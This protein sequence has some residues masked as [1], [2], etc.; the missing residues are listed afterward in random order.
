MSSGT[1]RSA[2]EALK[3]T[4]RGLRGNLVAE[5]AAGG[6]QVSE[7]AYN[8]LKFHGSYEQYDRDTATA[9]KKQGL[10]KDYGFMVRLRAPGGRLTAAQYL[11]LDGLADSHGNGTMRA[12]T[13]QTLQF[14][15]VRKDNL[16]SLIAA[17]NAT[18]LTTR[19]TCGDVVRNVITSPAPVRDAV[20]ARLEADARL[21]STTL[22]PRS[23]AY[24][25]IFLDEAP[26][27]DSGQEEEPLLGPAY[28]PRKFKIGIAVPQDNT[29]DALSN[30]LAFI[31]VWEGETLR[32]YNVAVGGGLGMT[33]NRADTYPRLASVL[34]SVGPDALLAT[35]EAVIRV[36]RDNGNRADRKRARLKYVVDDKGID[37]VR[38]EVERELGAKLADPLPTPPFAM[39][40]LLGWHAQ[41]DGRWWL[42]V[43]VPSGRIADTAEVRLRTALRRIVETFAPDPI[44]TPQQDLLLSNIA[45]SD[46]AAITALLREHGVT[47]AEELTPFARWALACPALPTCGLALTEAERV[48]EPIVAGLEAVLHRLGLTQERISLRITGCPNGCAHSYGGDIGLVGRVP[49]SYAIFV[50]GD[51]A[52]TRLSFKLLERVP[53]A[54]IAAVLAPLLA[55]YAAERQGGEGFGDYCARRGADALLGLVEN[56]RASAA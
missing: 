10:E 21:L 56:A 36:Q 47:L 55:A 31:A 3:E 52:G 23:R 51:F 9:L 24:D 37:W 39:P 48:R 46:R 7:D 12:T 4:S 11:A 16:K 26:R 50:G 30:D 53:Q 32:G 54:E 6:T 44:I 25:E 35:A 29:I 20:H 14:H 15:A 38:A 2:V 18:L 22:L 17:I 5:L 27:A 43:P 34:G 1:K 19:S 13:R 28:L 33:H 49:G 45:E 40:E 8:L 41:G 42:G